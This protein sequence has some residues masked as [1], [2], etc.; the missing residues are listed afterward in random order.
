MQPF[1]GSY[2]QKTKL[3]KI[4]TNPAIEVVAAIV[5]VVFTAAL[6]I[7]TE[8]NDRKTVFPVPVLAR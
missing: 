6:V 4:V 8:A 7:W 5:V 2:W 3:W 1:L